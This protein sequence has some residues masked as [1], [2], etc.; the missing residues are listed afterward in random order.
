MKF[1]LGQANVQTLGETKKGQNMVQGVNVTGRV[2]FLQRQ[3]EEQGHCIVG[4]CEARTPAGQKLSRNRLML[5]S[6]SSKNA[7][8][9]TELGC[10][11]WFNLD[12]DYSGQDGV[13]YRLCRE[14]VKVI[15]EDPRRLLVT[16]RS[17][18]MAFM[19]MDI[20]VG[21]A[22]HSNKPYEERLAWWKETEMILKTRPSPQPL[23][24]M[25]DANA[26]VGAV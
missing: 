12:N 1:K 3:F 17:T 23:V 5:A 16:V 22:P 24:T 21:H 18:K 6:G 15:H 14:D 26:R 19:R 4:I 2:R 10:E 25:M 13:S 7:A 8:K 11:L 9:A 20:L